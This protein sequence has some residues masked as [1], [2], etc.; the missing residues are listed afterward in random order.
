MAAKK[1]EGDVYNNN[2]NYDIISMCFSML[3][4]LN[5]AVQYK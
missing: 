5:C 4:M 1:V 2:D 3:N